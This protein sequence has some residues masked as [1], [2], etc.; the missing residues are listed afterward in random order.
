MRAEKTRLTINAFWLKEG[1][2]TLR[3]GN[4][5]YKWP[6]KQVTRWMR[7]KSS[8]RNCLNLPNR[9]KSNIMSL[10]SRRSSRN[11]SN[12]LGGRASPKSRAFSTTCWR[13]RSWTKSRLIRSKAFS[14]H[15]GP[16]ENTSSTIQWMR[17]CRKSSLKPS[18]RGMASSNMFSRRSWPSRRRAEH[19]LSMTGSMKK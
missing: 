11:L 9:L 13:S 3:S 15:L 14:S 16:T 12:S 18:V 2:T 10:R 6:G 8:K 19:G 5:R 1:T 17:L 4:A 7:Q